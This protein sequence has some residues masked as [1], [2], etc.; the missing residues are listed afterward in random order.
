MSR[1][2]FRARLSE[3]TFLSIVA[4][5]FVTKKFPFFDIKILSI[6]LGPKVLFTKET[7]SLISLKNIGFDFTV[8]ILNYV[9]YIRNH[10]KV[11]HRLPK[12]FFFIEG[13]SLEFELSEFEIF[14]HNYYEF[15][16]KIK[17]KA[18]VPFKSTEHAI[19]NLF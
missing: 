6:P 4:P 3:K 10:L 2:I 9:F 17:F 5:S 15:F 1:I 14:S 13:F 7:I 18:F 12:K 16:K 8:V 19:K 11:F